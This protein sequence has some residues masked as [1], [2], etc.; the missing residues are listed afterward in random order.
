[1]AAFLFCASHWTLMNSMC[2]CVLQVGVDDNVALARRTKIHSSK[3]YDDAWK[4]VEMNGSRGGEA[5]FPIIDDFKEIR[6]RSKRKFFGSKISDISGEK[7]RRR[8]LPRDFRRQTGT[9]SCYHRRRYAYFW[10]RVKSESLFRVVS[11]SRVGY[12]L[13]ANARRMTTKRSE[14]SP[15]HDQWIIDENDYWVTFCFIANHSS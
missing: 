15:R 10:I 12:C 13:G 6:D 7:E 1:M 11:T 8:P 9:G 4:I 3:L 14:R 2:V 5:A